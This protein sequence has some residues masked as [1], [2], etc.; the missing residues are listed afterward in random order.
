MQS[1]ENLEFDSDL[2]G[3]SAD[4]SFQRLLAAIRSMSEDVAREWDLPPRGVIL[5][6]NYGVKGK[7][8]EGKIVSYS[9]SISE[10]DY[11]ATEDDSRDEKRVKNPCITFKPS[12]A[13]ARK[14]FIEVILRTAILDRI[15]IP[16]EAV[17]VKT[18]LENDNKTIALPMGFGG[19]ANYFRQI[20]ELRLAL[21]KSAFASPFGC[22]SQYEECSNAKRCIHPNRL[23]STAC[24]YRRNLENGRIFYGKNRNRA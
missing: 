22:C 5:T 7:S 24:A 3:I 13:K 19:I 15:G 4:N 8:N 14:G 20:V 11:P 10:P 23:Y 12:P 21:Y 1:S 16:N 18:D 2:F 6:P 17:V 9:V